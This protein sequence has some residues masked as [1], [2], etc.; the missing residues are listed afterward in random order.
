MAP[1]AKKQK[2]EQKPRACAF[3]NCPVKHLCRS[4]ARFPREESL[5]SQWKILTQR[6]Y[7]SDEEISR[8]ARVCY[9]HF[10]N[11]QPSRKGPNSRPHLNLPPVNQRIF[12]DMFN[13]DSEAED[14]AH[15][16][17][18]SAVVLAPKGK[19]QRELTFLPKNAD[20]FKKSAD[21]I[22]QCIKHRTEHLR[23]DKYRWSLYYHFDFHTLQKITATMSVSVL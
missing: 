14:D 7:Y 16:K 15:K 4:R 11:S 6:E 21:R 2:F 1:V 10:D 22:L 13:K 18:I 9:M 8:G 19:K 23:A 3:R 12:D 17:L 20:I 5:R